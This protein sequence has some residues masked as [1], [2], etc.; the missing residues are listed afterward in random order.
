M[1]GPIY[2]LRSVRKVV[3]IAAS[4]LSTESDEKV[5]IQRALNVYNL[6]QFINHDQRTV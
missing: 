5:L 1:E 2:T 6:S 3:D 4:K